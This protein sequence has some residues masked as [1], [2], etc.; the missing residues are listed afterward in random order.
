MKVQLLLLLTTLLLLLQALLPL[1][2]LL[3][4]LLHLH[5]GGHQLALEKEKLDQQRLQL[6]SLWLKND[7]LPSL[8]PA[9]LLV[10][11]EA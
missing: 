9:L 1:L 2:L 8:W 11:V 10:V 3:L 6:L 5:A 7:A 4:L